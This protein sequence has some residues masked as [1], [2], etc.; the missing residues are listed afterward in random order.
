MYEIK[1]TFHK[2][3]LFG[4][5]FS[6]KTKNTRTDQSAPQVFYSIRIETT[7]KPSKEAAA[8]NVFS[9]VY[10]ID[11]TCLDEC[12]LSHVISRRRYFF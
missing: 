3:S 2:Q 12:F 5:L 8:K 10:V 6:L 4:C 1:F 7:R 11:A 9:S